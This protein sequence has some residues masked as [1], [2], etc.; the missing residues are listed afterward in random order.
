[1]RPLT[2][3]IWR[4]T[5]IALLC[6]N[7]SAFLTS[8]QSSPDTSFSW[9]SITP[10]PTI[11]Y[12]PCYTTFLCARLLVP[13]DWTNPNKSSSSTAAAIAI[14]TLPA[15]VPPSDPT[16]GGTITL[17]P[18]GPG[19]SG[20]T[21][22]LGLA[23]AFRSAVD[24]PNRHFEL[25]SFDPRGVGFST[26]GADC[27]AGDPF[28]R[29]ADVLQ[30]AQAVAPLAGRMAEL[31]VR[32]RFAAAEGLG[33]VCA[34][35]GD[36]EGSILRH[37]STADVARDMLEIVERFDELRFGEKM[38][39]KA[40]LQYWGF[41]Y[42]TVLGQVFALLFPDRV[43]KMVL[44]GVGDLPDLLTG[45][46]KTSTADAE[47]A[48]D[49]FYRTCLDA[50]SKC[51]LRKDT[52]TSVGDIRGR[53]TSLLTALEQS[54][55][56]ATYGGRIQLVTSYLVR[57][58]IR[59]T[60]YDPLNQFGPLASILAGAVAGNYTLLLAAQAVANTTACA[61]P[62]TGDPPAAYTWIAD[63]SVA[64]F[65][66][67]T[68]VAGSRTLAWSE[69][70]ARFHAN[71]SASTGEAWA[72][73][74][75]SCSGWPFTPAYH[76]PQPTYTKWLGAAPLLL[77]ST[78]YDPATPLGNAYA[79]ARRYPESAAVVVQ[80]SAGHTAFISS[81]SRCVGAILGEYFSSGKVPDG[82]AVCEPDCVASI[83]AVACSR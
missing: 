63:A 40:M 78:R 80:E 17:N 13:L 54:P 62:D 47:K 77:V 14:L 24:T 16:F 49:V 28:R 42:G 81:P 69:E 1:M 15:T 65:C 2:Q 64:I 8:R 57:D 45:T 82:G 67:D 19:V 60:L 25:L 26:P 79:L 74:L 55:V 31:G 41:S 44:D 30:H 38:G 58:A 36:E 34:D 33:K 68:A 66:S 46:W 73:F 4:W 52:D 70:V 50:G 72:R 59:N 53:V 29:A 71:Q 27:Y 83:P 12:H 37:M 75:L 9:S 7:T 18:G 10:S 43:G 48:V 6:T 5:T 32:V 11:Q 76:I 3:R 22:L 39:K 35:D 56:P 51:P 23:S 61:A 20:V 21:T